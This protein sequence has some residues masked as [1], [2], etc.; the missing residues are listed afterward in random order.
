MTSEELSA[1]PSRLIFG[2]VKFS[3]NSE[4]VYEWQSLRIVVDRIRGQDPDGGNMSLAAR[5]MVESKSPFRCE[6]DKLSSVPI[7]LQ[8]APK[9]DNTQRSVASLLGVVHHLASLAE[10][11]ALWAGVAALQQG[12]LDDP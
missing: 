7:F 4:N 6:S 3:R 2:G 10:G 1:L 11:L 5:L 12:N 8:T 9:P